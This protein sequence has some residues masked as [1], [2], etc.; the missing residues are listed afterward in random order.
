MPT[1][2]IRWIV[3]RSTVPTIPLRDSAVTLNRWFPC[4]APLLVQSDNDPL[5]P[6]PGGFEGVRSVAI[7]P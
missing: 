4:K 3:M 7:E 1:W 6:Q 5:L 2:S